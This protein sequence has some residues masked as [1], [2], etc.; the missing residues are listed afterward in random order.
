MIRALMFFMIGFGV[1]F[2]FLNPEQRSIGQLVDGAKH[3][4]NQS[5]TKVEE[6][7]RD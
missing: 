7:T 2:L 1:C 3:A 4:I 6:L 5:A